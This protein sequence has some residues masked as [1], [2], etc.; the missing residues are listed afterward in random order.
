MGLAWN[1]REW[2][3][4]Q[5][6]GKAATASNIEFHFLS[7]KE[8]FD[9]TYI[10]AD[11]HHSSAGEWVVLPRPSGFYSVSV[12]TRPVYALPKELCLTFSC[13]SREERIGNS[14]MI[15]PPIEEV[16]LE[17]G[18]LLSVLVREPLLPLG[19]RRQDDKPLMYG[20]PYG[21]LPRRL[22][23]SEPAQATGVNSVEF[24]AILKRLASGQNQTEDSLRSRLQRDCFVAS[25]LAMTTTYSVIAS[26]AK[27]SR[28]AALWYQASNSHH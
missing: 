21:A 24:A 19:V 5:A 8:L 11:R 23:S 17:F 10:S 2:L 26:A 13:F 14:T 28:W 4:A 1:T 7:G 15:G 22:R 27:Q 12:V 6:G 9:E 18:A 16:A 25:L 20:A 3:A